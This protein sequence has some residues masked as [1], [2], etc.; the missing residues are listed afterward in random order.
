MVDMGKIQDDVLR[1]IL[2]KRFRAAGDFGLT[3]SAI[4]SAAEYAQR[5]M[6]RGEQIKV[7]LLLQEIANRY[8]NMASDL[9]ERSKKEE[10]ADD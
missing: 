6:T 4:S 8:F 7:C 9:V 1:D 2:Q 3:A 5:P 10:S